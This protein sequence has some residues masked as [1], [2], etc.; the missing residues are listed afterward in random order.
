MSC[1]P[2]RYYLLVGF[3]LLGWDAQAFWSATPQ[4]M[5]LAYEAYLACRGGAAASATPLTRQELRQLM[6]KQHKARNDDRNS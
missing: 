5:R 2:W 3:G 1:Y 4:D 6:E